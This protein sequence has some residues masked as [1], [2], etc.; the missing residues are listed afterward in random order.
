MEKITGQLFGARLVWDRGNN[1]FQG[2]SCN[3]IDDPN[4][5]QLP[6][7]ISNKANLSMSLSKDEDVVDQT[8]TLDDGKVLSMAQVIEVCE[9]MNELSINV[10]QARKDA[11]AAALAAAQAGIQEEP[12][13]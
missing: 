3:Y 5:D 10:M 7:I 12:A 13:E 6:V 2:T 11:E 1:Y 4:D 8:I 9:K